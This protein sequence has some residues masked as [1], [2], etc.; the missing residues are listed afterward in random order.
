[1]FQES[2]WELPAVTF[3]LGTWREEKKSLYVWSEGTYS[4]GHQSEFTIDKIRGKEAPNERLEVKE[5]SKR[6]LK[7]VCVKPRV[8]WKP[9]VNWK[10]EDR[11]S[12][13]PV[14]TLTDCQ[15]W[16][17]LMCDFNVRRR[18]SAVT[19][20][21]AEYE[22]LISWCL[23]FSSSWRIQRDISSSLQVSPKRLVAQF[24][25]THIA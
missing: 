13:W 11:Q 17:T 2:E 24:N 4:F 25:D 6:P 21:L 19:Q 8:F 7:K 10:E 3:G 23:L 9:R 18:R 15:T 5:N 1:M 20:T 12:V 14:K 22:C 16:N